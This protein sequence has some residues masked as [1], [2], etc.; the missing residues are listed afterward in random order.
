LFCDHGLL[1]RNEGVVK[2]TTPFSLKLSYQ[3]REPL[4][5]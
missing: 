1:S 2:G 5:D 3:A 4:S